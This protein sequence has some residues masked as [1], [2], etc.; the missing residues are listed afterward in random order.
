MLIPLGRH[1]ID[2][3]RNSARY[4]SACAKLR[5]DEGGERRADIVVRRR[6]TARTVPPSRPHLPA[7]ASPSLIFI[8][9]MGINYF[10]QFIV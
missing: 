9:I 3:I 4:H 6:V 2:I 10:S 7:L 5:G 8:F 1:S